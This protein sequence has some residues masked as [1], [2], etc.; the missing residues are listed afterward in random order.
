MN[1][2][3]SRFRHT[4]FIL[5][6]VEQSVYGVQLMPAKAGEI[7]QLIAD[8]FAAK[9]EAELEVARMQHQIYTMRQKDEQP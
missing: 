2:L 7:A 6:E 4:L 1:D 5:R 3:E 8:L 9:R